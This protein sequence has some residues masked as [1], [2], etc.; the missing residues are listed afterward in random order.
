[1]AADPVEVERAEAPA[2]KWATSTICTTPA[3][4]ADCQADYAANSE[5]RRKFDATA[6]RQYGR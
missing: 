4:V 3:T 2:P 5:L 6:K 1:M